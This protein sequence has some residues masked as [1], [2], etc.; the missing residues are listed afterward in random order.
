M[1]SNK[2]L[3]PHAMHSNKTKR[4]HETSTTLKQDPKT[5]WNKQCAQTRPKDPM[6]QAMHSNKTQRP[7]ETS[8]ELKQD[9]K[10]RWKE[11]SS[12]TS[13][14][15]PWNEQ[16]ALTRPKGPLKWA[17]RSNKTQRTY[18]TR[19]ALQQD[20]IPHKTSNVLKQDTKTPLYKHC[21]QITPN[22]PKKRA[23]C[24]NKTQRP[25]ETSNAL[26]QQT[27]N[28]WN[29]QC[30]QIRPKDP[31]K[32]AMRSQRAH[33]KSKALKQAPKPHEMSNAR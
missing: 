28:L 2:T 10:S 23:L 8:N 21:T 31:M 9:P 27:K 4:P 12:Q 7:H 6:K 22:D 16:C 3:R 15:T 19:N 33:E 5:P 13:P 26:K 20:P 25:Y 1:R 11:K 24:S 29:E 17:V 30:A 32:Q 14:K 18:E